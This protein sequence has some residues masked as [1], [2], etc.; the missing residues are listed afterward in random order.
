MKL[1]EITG[2]NDEWADLIES[3]TSGATGSASIA[4]VANPMGSINRRPS[5]FGYIPE[6]PKQRAKGKRKSRK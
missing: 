4:G 3:A 2:P 1:R 5:L 6:P